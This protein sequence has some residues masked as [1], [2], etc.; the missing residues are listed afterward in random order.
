MDTHPRRRVRHLIVILDEIHHGS[1]RQPERRSPAPLFLPAVPLPLVEI[2][3]FGSRHKFLR[4]S[5]VVG[6]VSV[7]FSG[8]SNGGGMVIIVVPQC[9]EPVTTVLSGAK[10]PGFLWLVLA[11]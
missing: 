8:E 6:I 11:D 9:V 2:P 1:L 10:Q 4:R 7:R 5:P 3:V